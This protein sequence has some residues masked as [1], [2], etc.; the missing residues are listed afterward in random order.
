[1]HGFALEKKIPL[2]FLFALL[3]QG[4]SAVWWASAKDVQDRFRDLRLVEL[5]SRVAQARDRDMEIVQRLARLEAH[6]EE[7]AAIL[8]RI[9]NLLARK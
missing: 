6:G 1:M 4:A 5:E 7:Q 3:L 9:E 2:A 8:R